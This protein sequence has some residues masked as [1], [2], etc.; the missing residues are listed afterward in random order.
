MTLYNAFIT[1]IGVTVSVPAMLRID[2]GDGQVEVCA[3][4]SAAEDT[5]RAFNITLLTSDD[6]GITKI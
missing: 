3:T 1:P 5:E 2:E 4:L 6:T